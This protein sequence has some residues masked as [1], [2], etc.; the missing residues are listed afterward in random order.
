MTLQQKLKGKELCNTSFVCVRSHI[1]QKS[2][3][4]CFRN[5]LQTFS[6]CVRQNSL[7]NE[8]TDTYQVE[9]ENYAANW[10][11]CMKIIV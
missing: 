5:Y 7:R 9:L 1:G 4:C 8:L 11:E 10:P 2:I 3:T 6:L